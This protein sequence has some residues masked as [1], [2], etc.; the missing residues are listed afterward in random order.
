MLQR[1]DQSLRIDEAQARQFPNTAHGVYELP[2]CQQ[3]VN[4]GFARLV[5]E[6][7][8]HFT[9]AAVGFLLGRLRYADRPG[10]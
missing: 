6:R 4:F 10:P 2:T 8:Q 3:A 1:S 9:Y 7:D 5:Q